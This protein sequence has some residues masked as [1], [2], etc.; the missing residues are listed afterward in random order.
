MPRPLDVLAV[1]EVNIDL[2]L[3]GVPRIPDWGAE[4]LAE[5]MSLR[6][7]GSTANFACAA[8]ALGLRVALVSWVGEDDFGSFLL[9]ELQ[10]MSVITD[11]VRRA[12][13]RPTGITV[14]LSG[15][16][17]RAFVTAMGT[18]DYLRGEHVPDE[19][20]ASARHVHVGSYFLQS[21]LQSDL[22]HLFRRAHA[23]GAFTS[24]DAGYDPAEQWDAGLRQALFE[25]DVFLPN[26]IEAAAIS[27][28]DDPSQAAAVLAA[29][30]PTVVV[31][32]GPHGA[33]AHDGNAFYAS[34]GF[35]VQ[36]V[37]T[38]ACG[39]AF[40]AGFLRARLCGLPLD[41]CLKWGNA[42]GALMAT[43]PGNDTSVLAPSALESLMGQ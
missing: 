35:K 14:A 28:K 24:L 32:L 20:L 43:V 6:L 22:T 33:C 23:V 11:Y 41:K 25:T 38:T 13:D 12:P 42:C 1:G 16:N 39:D 2:I 8:A 5:G 7:G 3:H 37:D 18:I 34:P 19:L 30:G 17:D 31:K 15:R 26:E 27:R 9:S 29:L 36:V 40:N 21:R 4:V 10:R